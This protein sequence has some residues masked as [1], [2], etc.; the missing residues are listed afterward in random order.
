MVLLGIDPG[1][2]N[3]GYGV[4]VRRFHRPRAA[5]GA[6]IDTP[7]AQ[8]PERRLAI[9]H[10]RLADLVDEHDLDA[11]ALEALYFGQTMRPA[12]AVGQARGVV[13]VA[14]GQRSVACVDYTRQQVMGAVCGAGRA[15]KGQ[16]ARMVQALASLPGSPRPDHAADALAA[17]ICHANLVPFAAAAAAG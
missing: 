17:A 6:V 15:D 4:V 7:A 9:L 2:G 16:V 10:E 13:L 5:D 1:L 3:C 14:A 11:V 12:F 8:P